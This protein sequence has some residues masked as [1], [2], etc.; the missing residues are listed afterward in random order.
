VND[1]KFDLTHWNLQDLLPSHEGPEFDQFLAGFEQQVTAFENIRPRLTADMTAAEFG[2]VL[3]AYD[4]LHATA[5]RMGAYAHL[6]FTENTQS[7]A[8]LGFMGRIDQLGAEVA[9]RTLFFSLW[10]K[11]L[12]DD[13]AARLTSASGDYRYHLES[14]RRFRPHTLSEPEEKIVNLKDVNGMSALITLYDMITN[15]FTFELEVDGHKESM[16]RGELMAYARDPNPDIRAAVY[17]ELYDRVYREHANTLGQIYSYRVRD[18]FSENVQLRHHSSPLAV[19]NLINDIPDAATDTLLDVC[20]QN[21]GLFQRYFTLKARWLGIPS[22]KLRR[23]D[24]YAPVV[25]SDKRYSYPEAVD[26]VLDSLGAFEPQVAD[27]ARR[28]FADRH[29]DAESRPGKQGGAFCASVLPKLTPYVLLNFVGRPR[30][31]ATMAHELGHAIHAL[32]AENHTTLT[33]HSSLPLAETASV[34]SEMILTDRLLSQETDASVRRD[35]LATQID[36]AYATVIRQAYFVLFEREAHELIL[37]G[38]TTDQLADRYLANLHEQFGDVMDVGDEFRWEWVSIPHIYHTPFYCYAYSFGQLLVLSLYR[39][40]KAEGE[41][42][43]PKYLKILSYGGSESPAKI[44]AEAGIDITSPAFWQGGF[45]VIK[46]LIDELEAIEA[47][48]A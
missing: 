44:L 1:G 7:Q 8:A 30:D 21:V 25:S 24:L 19:R 40:F 46:G 14:L 6:W 15:R 23:C 13:D 43:K 22:G 10:W 18:W 37:K 12:D 32:M 34:F 5:S 42:F 11:S 39:R 16:T 3:R 48:S 17:H 38:A 36:D 41:S 20:R 31:V 29:I 47:V 4:A 9:N 33:F 27:K 28:V 35:I 26:M 2:D 45:D